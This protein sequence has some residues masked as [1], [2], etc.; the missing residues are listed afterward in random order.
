MKT[1]YFSCVTMCVVF[2]IGCMDREPAPMC[3]VPVEI[4]TNNA[5]STSFDGVDLLVV[6]DNSG[7]MIEEQAILSTGFFTLVNSLMNPIPGPDWPYPEVEN[8]RVAVVSSDLGL[9]YGSDHSTEGFPYGNTKVTSCTNQPPRGDDGEFQSDMT[10]DVRVASGEIRCKENGGQCPEGWSCDAG[11]CVSPSGDPELVSCRNLRDEAIWAETVAGKK[12]VYLATQLACIGQLGT[13]GC[14]VEQQLESSVRGLS[15]S[16]AQ[17]SFMKDS[18]VLA[19]LVVSDEEDCSIKD[20]GLF[21]TPEWK[22]GLSVIAD[23]PTTGL[24][25]T[26]CNMPAS[27][28]ENYLFPTNRYWSKLVELKNNL[29]HAVVFAAIV[30]VPKG[31]DSPCQGKGNELGECL[32]DEKMQLE[33]TLQTNDDSNVR[34][35]ESAC[36]RMEE[37][38]LVT[39]ARPGRRYVKVA[40]DFGANGYV[41]SICNK[42]WSP[43]MKEIAKVIAGSVCSHCYPKRLEWQGMSTAE[44]KAENCPD[45]GEAK[46]EVV[47]TF[48]Y[49]GNNAKEPTCP[50]ELRVDPNKAI[51]EYKKEADG[52]SKV[53]LHCP[54]PKLPTPID[55]GRADEMYEGTKGEE[56]LGWYYCE[57]QQED[58]DET[59]SD[60]I[61]NDGE[62]GIDCDDPKCDACCSDT[63]VGCKSTCKFGVELTTAAQNATRG[64]MISV[65]CLTQFSFMDENCQENT[66]ASCN[67]E[68]DNDGN[69]AWD[70]KDGKSGNDYHFA[71]PHCCPMT[72]NGKLCVI[73]ENATKAN[74]GGNTLP[75]ACQAAALL[76]GCDMSNY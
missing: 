59:C 41:Y 40:E 26:A 48:E 55:C 28:E 37:D 53:L 46:C 6:V 74:C 60:G 21:D 63:K 75:D 20:K 7:S 27:N 54:L 2:A 11:K 19:V 73:D 35:F 38:E 43:A 25:N 76:L 45:C 64:N 56:T 66:N 14:G 9:Q 44:Q 62:D 31:D 51:K 58:F 49:E 39:S 32:R 12:N 13:D 57:N 22:S 16:D 65:Q 1:T 70:C 23:D 8:M 10:D 17:T 36:D 68:I 50:S 30:G 67:D 72:V 15:R 71:D 33:V 52:Q 42:D 47:A 18:H 24:L 69:G 5:M 4:S 29:A 61:D 3:P 34:H